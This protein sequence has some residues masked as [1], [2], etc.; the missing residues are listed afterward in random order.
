[1]EICKKNIIQNHPCALKDDNQSSCYIASA[2]YSSDSYEVAALKKWR[3]DVLKNH[4]FY[5]DF[6]FIVL[7]NFA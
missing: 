2:I 6:S 5:T 1:L 4:F 7:Q 3:D